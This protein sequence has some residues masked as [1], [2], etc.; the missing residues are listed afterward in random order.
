MQ[1][2]RTPIWSRC[3]QYCVACLRDALAASVPGQP[4]RGLPPLE[5]SLRADRR[6]RW[7]CAGLLGPCALQAVWLLLQGAVLSAA[8][9]GLGAGGLAAGLWQLRR[10]HHR[11]RQGLCLQPDGRALLRGAGGSREAWIQPGSLRLGPWLL[12]LLREAGGA[13]VRLLLGPGS[14]GAE[15]CAALGR[16][17]QR[18]PAGG[19]TPPGPLR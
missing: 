17:L 1:H 6:A 11:A 7:L 9:V 18:A 2:P 19:E 15:D 8:V 14:L 5:L 10:D 16:W 3:W 4:P 13:R 12:L